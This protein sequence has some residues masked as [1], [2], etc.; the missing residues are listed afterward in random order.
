MKT[1]VEY[2]LIE[3]D[4]NKELSIRI[5]NLLS[6]DWQPFGSPFFRPTDDKSTSGT[7]I[8]E[9]IRFLRRNGYICQAVVKY[10]ID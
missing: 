1:I 2:I 7:G 5:R 6:D 10:K 3:G 4:D 9:G 8:E